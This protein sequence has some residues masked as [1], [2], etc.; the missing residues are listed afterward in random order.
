MQTTASGVGWVPGTNIARGSTCASFE[1]IGR[2]S[3]AAFPVKPSPSGIRSERSS[4]SSS[5]STSATTNS[6][7][8]A[9]SQMT[10]SSQRINSRKVAST[11]A[12]TASTDCSATTSRNRPASRR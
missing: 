10:T 7:S 2:R 1:T 9:G 12:N 8:P 6:S 4:S 3:L 11:R 5:P